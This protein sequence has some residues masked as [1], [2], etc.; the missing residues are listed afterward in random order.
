MYQLKTHHIKN[1]LVVLLI[2]TIIVGTGCN[3]TKY[4]KPGQHLLRKNSVK[5]N[6]NKPITKKAELSDNLHSQIVQKPNKYS[7][8]VFPFKLWLYN[9][10]YKK[11]QN[12]TGNFQL[13]TK[14]VEKPVVLDSSTIPKSNLYMQSYLYNQGYFY[15]K[16]KDSIR[17]KKKKAFVHYNVE[18]GINYKI[19]KVLFD[20]DDPTVLKF[21]KES[22]EESLLESGTDFSTNTLDEERSRITAML[23]NNGY[24]KFSQENITFQ[25][26]TLGQPYINC[27]TNPLASVA[28]C[29]SLLKNPKKQTLNVTIIIRSE[30][31][32][33]YRRYGIGKVYVLPDFTDKKDIAD[34]SNMIRKEIGE[35]SFLYHNY[36]VKENVIAKH[37]FLITGKYYTQDNYDQ[38]I[39]KLNELGIFQYVR[40]YMIEDSSK[41]DRPLNCVILLSP[42]KKYDLTANFDVSNATTYDMGMGVTL[43]LR[44]R[45]LGKG[46]NQ[47][48]ASVTGGLET[49][50][51]GNKGNNFF[52]HFLLSNKNLGG[53]VSII[54]PKFLV[55][56]SQSNVSKKNVPRTI[57]TLGSNLIDRVG[58]FTLINTSAY[59]TYNWHETKTKTWDFS[60]AFVNV[61]KLPH[62]D[63]SFQIT[64]NNNKFLKNSYKENFIEGENLT[65][66]FT[67]ANVKNGKNYSKLKTSIEEAGGLLSAAVGFTDVLKNAANIQYAQ[68]VKLDM[69]A[70]HFFTRRHSTTAFRFLAGVGI[71]YDRSSTLP[72]IKQYFA[73]GAYSMRGWTVRTLGPGAY[74]DPHFNSNTYNNIDNIGD[75][76]LEMNGEFRFD[77]LPLFGGSVK[78]NGALFADAGNIWL[79][80]KD[81]NYLDGEFNISRLGQDIAV[82]SGAGIRFDFAGLIVLR[83]DAAFPIKKPY[84]A[85]NF[86]WVINQI[87][88]FDGSW[89][90]NNMVLQLA[91]GYPF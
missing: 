61:L 63:S 35:M 23:R 36:Y 79:A 43:S 74:L 72:Y 20:I 1:V 13:K 73:G 39:A 70:E 7:L 47:L 59:F 41:P 67:D 86:G 45:N 82:S 38:T 57:V 28:Y 76:K 81:K 22:D 4:L 42:T 14:T 2:L 37:I 21:I 68:Y 15:A 8:K 46:S 62:I 58:Y 25:I 34:S 66:T 89:R 24:F 69:D 40:V 33:D 64:L 31:Q 88:P 27:I 9:L 18:T 17:F 84:V 51:F 60:P 26:D 56:F 78:M 77:I 48:S 6:S 91:L 90:A 16:V 75:I 85:E 12:D 44:N 55:P 11:Y 52:D 50:Y 71:P 5:I 65:F 80:R 32:N 3:S 54:F 19:D 49:K 83:L 30:E 10:R 53:N 29:V 87:S